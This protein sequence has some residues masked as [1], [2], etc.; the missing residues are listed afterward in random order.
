MESHGRG[1]LEQGGVYWTLVPELSNGGGPGKSRR[2][3]SVL[4]WRFPMEGGA[5]EVA[6]GPPALGCVLSN[7]GWV[8]S[9]M[10]HPVCVGNCFV[11]W[12]RV[13]MLAV[14]HPLRWTLWCPMEEGCCGCRVSSSLLGRGEFAPNAT[15]AQRV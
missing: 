10:Y 6:H 4:E 1:T 9:H 7:G 14:T 12:R 5:S 13:G 8:M 11:Q 2:T 15:H 3:L